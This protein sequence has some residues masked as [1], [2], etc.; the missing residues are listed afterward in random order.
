MSAYQNP[1]AMDDENPHWSERIKGALTKGMEFAIEHPVSATVSAYAAVYLTQSALLQTS[2]YDASNPVMASVN[3]AL[4]IGLPA[5]VGAASLVGRHERKKQDERV[6]EIKNHYRMPV[7]F[8]D[9]TQKLP[10]GNYQVEDQSL[11]D[12]IKS[13]KSDPDAWQVFERYAFQSEE[14][15]EKVSELLSAEAPNSSA[16]AQAGARHQDDIPRPGN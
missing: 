3:A 16:P 5:A 13:L 7:G 6:Q 10:V 1:P 9:H 2:G 15:K 11:Q 4:Q 14:G 8:H 12:A